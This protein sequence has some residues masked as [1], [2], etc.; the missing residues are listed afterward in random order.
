MK[1]TFE[2]TESQRIAL[3]TILS[4]HLRRPDA[5]ELHIDCSTFPAVETT[6]GELLAKFLEVPA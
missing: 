1:Y 6:P 4:E 3:C 5:S 2:L